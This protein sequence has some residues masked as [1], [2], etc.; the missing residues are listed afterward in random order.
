M[1][2]V[3]VSVLGPVEAARNGDA[4]DLGGPQQRALAALLAI[5]APAVVSVETLVDVL[6]PEHPPPRANK[7]IQTYISRLRKALG[8]HA[9]ERRGAG[10]A[11]RLPADS[12]DVHRFEALVTAGHPSEALALWRGPALADVANLPGLRAE[13]D[14]LEEL[15]LRALEQRIDSDLAAGLHAEA[16]SELQA[17]VDA[18]PFRET[19]GRS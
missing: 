8:E 9:I 7:V 11:L 18:H 15:R 5:R 17:L 1:G 14:R 19:C 3:I 6:W 2:D 12:V 10:Y 16:I 13:A 4:I